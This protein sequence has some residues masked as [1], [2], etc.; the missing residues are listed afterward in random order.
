MNPTDEQIRLELTLFS[1]GASGPLSA[2]PAAQAER[3]LPAK[4]LLRESVAELFGAGTEVDDAYVV[5]EVREGDGVTGFA[6][7]SLPEAETAIG[8]SAFQGTPGSPVAYSAQLASLEGTFYTSVRLVNLAGAER[9]AMLSPV[10]EDGSSLAEPTSV[11]LPPGGMLQRDVAELFGLPGE[12]LLVGS[13]KIESDAPGVVGDIIFGSPDGQIAA[14]MPL[15]TKV[16]TKAIFSQVANIPGSFFT[17]LALFNPSNRE[18]RVQVSV[19]MADGTL[20]GTTELDLA[21]GARLSRLVSEL[22]PSPQ[23]WFR[24]TSW[25]SPA[26]VWWPSSYSETM[27]RLGLQRCLRSSLIS[28]SGRY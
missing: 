13:L 25:L 2:T 19:F 28:E 4:S 12:S 26:A 18:V 10:S 7:V 17:G 16:F 15:Q 5:A 22:V 24:D 8:L 14:G 20:A 21:S 23:M 11:T 9:V 6:L 1:Q 3:I 27:H